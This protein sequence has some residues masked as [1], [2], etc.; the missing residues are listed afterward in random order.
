MQTSTEFSE[1]LPDAYR[2]KL[3][4]FEGPLDL[5]L[6]LIRKNELDICEVSLTQIAQQYL[7]Y[8]DSMER[9]NLEVA[10]DFILVAATLILLK[11]RA[12]LPSEAA[13]MEEDD[14]F[15]SPMELV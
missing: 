14:E 6:Y 3:D 8:V 5:L 9:L 12:L 11:S 2:V 4:F 7:N 15:V 13:A 10:G 1:S